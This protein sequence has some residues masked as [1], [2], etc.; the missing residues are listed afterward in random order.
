MIK[1]PLPTTELTLA[2]PRGYL[3]GPTLDL[4]E[5]AGFNVDEV[6]ADDRKPV[7]EVGEGRSII[8]APHLD[9]PAYVEYGAADAG[10][11]GKELLLEQDHSLYE[12]LDLGYGRRHIVYATQDNGAPSGNGIRRAGVMR[13][14]SRYPE[15][16][17]RYFEGRG[18]RVEVIELRGPL[19]QAPQA[20]LAEGIVD[21]TASSGSMRRNGLVEREEIAVCSARL[22]ANRVSFKLKAEMIDKLVRRLGEITVASGAEGV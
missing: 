4:L 15:V 17:R 22:V 6:R 5:E 12:L 19:E 21:L 18:R 10:V 3:M 9:I 20:G 11:V 14:A 2:V 13:V 1:S 7:F 8:T 16:S